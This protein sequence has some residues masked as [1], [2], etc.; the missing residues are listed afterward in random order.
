M[1]FIFGIHRDL[2]STYYQLF[3]T[4]LTIPYEIFRTNNKY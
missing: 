1:L 4:I 2:D 3:N